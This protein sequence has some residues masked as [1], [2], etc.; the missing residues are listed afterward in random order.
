MTA[1]KKRDTVVVLKNATA[2]EPPPDNLYKELNE[3]INSARRLNIKDLKGHP[4]DTRD[5][6]DRIHDTK[7]FHGM[8]KS[9]VLATARR[10]R[11]EE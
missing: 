4:L 11:S 7:F 3:F 5:L 2:A 10:L 9:W 8:V 1:K 6:I